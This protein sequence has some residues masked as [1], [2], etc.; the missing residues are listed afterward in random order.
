MTPDDEKKNERKR[1]GPKAYRGEGELWDIKDRYLESMRASNYAENSIKGA[2]GNLSYFFRWLEGQGI[3]RVAEVTERELYYF[4]MKLR[5]PKNGL[6][7][8]I[9]HVQQRLLAVKMFFRWLAKRGIV[10]ES[11]AEDMEMPRVPSNLPHVILTKEEARQFLNAPDLRSPVGFR[12]KALLEMIY[13]T[14]VRSTEAIN[15]RIEDVDFEKGMLAVRKA[16]GRK[17]RIVPVPEFTLR[18]V[19]EY[20]KKIRPRFAKRLIRGDITRPKDEGTLFLNFT[21]RK[22]TRN[23][24]GTIF[25]RTRERAGIP[26]HITALTLRHSI[27]T[28]LLE[29]GMGLRYIQEFLGH[30]KIS[31]TQVYAAVTL[32]GLRA[33]YNRIHPRERRA[34]Q[35]Q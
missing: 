29:Q 19:Q 30:E 12:D 11:V 24:L 33:H 32:T 22:L 7:P 8:R 6:A 4:S 5:E 34:R 3:T 26:K 10:K 14:G 9:T 31:T 13:A 28:A 2:H 23:D 16:K 21:G 20:L 25:K 27:A 1:P 18:C 17:P 35:K 15:I